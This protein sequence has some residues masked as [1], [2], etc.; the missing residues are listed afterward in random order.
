MLEKYRHCS[1]A[2]AWHKKKKRKQSQLQLHP[3]WQKQVCLE[4]E[5]YPRRGGAKWRGDATAIVRSGS[6]AEKN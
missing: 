4:P 5:N 2:P 3:L 6:A 1:V